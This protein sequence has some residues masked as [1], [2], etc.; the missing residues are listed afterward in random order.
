M[1][2]VMTLDDKV[3]AYKELLDKKD[4]L[5]EQ[6]KANNEELKNMEQEIARQMVDIPEVD[7]AD[8]NTAAPVDSADFVS[9]EGTQENLPFN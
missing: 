5:A 6:T 1:E 4:E 3:R 2:T 9:V 7:E 8:Y